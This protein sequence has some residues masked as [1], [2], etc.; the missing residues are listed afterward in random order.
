MAA[1]ERLKAKQ[2]AADELAERQKGAGAAR[3]ADGE[4]VQNVTTDQEADGSPTTGDLGL[5]TT[6]LQLERDRYAFLRDR[7]YCY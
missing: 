2:D 1:E 7:S 4:D 5:I 6:A 3:E